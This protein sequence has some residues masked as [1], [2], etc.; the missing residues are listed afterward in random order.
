MKTNEEWEVPVLLTIVLQ[1]S[2]KTKEEW[3]VP[4]LLTI[5]LQR[6]PKTRTRKHKD[7]STAL[8]ARVDAISKMRSNSNI[9]VENYEMVGFK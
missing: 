8:M 6:S 5:V 1:R 4:V 3:E 9:S 7:T 2:P